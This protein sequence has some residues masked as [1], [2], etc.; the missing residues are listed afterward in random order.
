MT[1]SR[2]ALLS[3]SICVGLAAPWTATAATTSSTLLPTASKVSAVTLYR[4]QALVSR[5][6]PLPNRTGELQLLVDDLPARVDG[7]SLSAT[8]S[9]KDVVVRSVRYRT[10]A[11]SQA[12]NPEVA[13]LDQKREALNNE[14]NVVRQR[15]RLVDEK[16]RVYQGQMGFVAPTAK[17]E[18]AKGVLDPKKLQAVTS[19]N[20]AARDALFEAKIALQDRQRSIRKETRLLSRKRRELTRGQHSYRRQAVLFVHKRKSG[21]GSLRLDYLVRSASWTPT[22]NVRASRDGRSV[23]VEYLADVRQMSGEAWNR[24]AVTLSTATPRMSAESP[25]LGPL[26]VGLGGAPTR[27]KRR[28]MTFKSYALSQSRIRAQQQR[29]NSSPRPAQGGWMMNKLAADGQRLELNADKDVVR[30]GRRAVKAAEEALA[31]S[32][33]LPGRMS[34]ESRSDRQ[35]IK[36]ATLKLDATVFYEAVPLFSTY[37]TRYA[38]V[39]NTSDLPLLAGNYRAYSDGEF[40][41]RGAIGVIARD[42]DFTIGLGADTQLRCYR[43]L[44]DKKADTSWGDRV[45]TFD[46]R[47]RIE[48]YKRQAVDVRLYDRIPASKTEDLQIKLVRNSTGLSKEAVYVRDDRPKGILRWDLKVAA[49][50]SGAKAKDIRYRFEMKYAKDK[51]VGREARGL[52]KEMRKDFRAMSR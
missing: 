43:E 3:L 35:M 29:L 39:V 45:Q 46:Y 20:L 21:R 34:L 33:R 22:Y 7:S 40:V 8:S 38:R 52:M 41:G 2:P 24:A 47:L 9:H 49:G 27:K 4:G 1:R 12:T 18:M 48:S 5:T 14:L 44:V 37:V 25:L 17:V 15:I 36:I 30:A 13:K 26:W 28:R 19:A 31:V 42:Q 23:Q 50:T 51:H 32:Y 16:M 6:V 10:K 11:T